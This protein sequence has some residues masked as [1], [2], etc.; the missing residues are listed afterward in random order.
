LQKLISFLEIAR[1]SACG[2]LRG[3]AFRSSILNRSLLRSGPW[4]R[5][6]DPLSGSVSRSCFR[7]AAPEAVAPPAPAVAATGA[8]QPPIH[9]AEVPRV[10]NR[11]SQIF[12][13]AELHLLHRHP[14]EGRAE[15]PDDPIARGSVARAQSA[16]AVRVLGGSRPRSATSPTWAASLVALP[17]VRVQEHAG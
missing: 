2:A 12:L 16:S 17:Q 5:H 1:A 9:R 15:Q 11:Q 10:Q 6:A 7:P 4:D 13:W 3:V 8:G 14:G